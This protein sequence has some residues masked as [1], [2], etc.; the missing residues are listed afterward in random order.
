MFAF[1]FLLT[2]LVSF[3]NG[4][5]LIYVKSISFAVRLVRGGQSLSPS[6]ASDTSPFPFSFSTKIDVAKN[7]FIFSDTIIITG[8]NTAAIIRVSIGEYRIN[9]GDWVTD[10]GQVN[11]G[12]Q[13][14]HRSSTDDETSV[15]SRLTVGD[16]SAT[17]SSIT[18]T[19]VMGQPEIPGSSVEGFVTG[20]LTGLCH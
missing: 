3:V 9:Q 5:D 17:I 6:A 18:L 15:V 1:N 2:W 7:T 11:Q 14:R 19:E 10:N 8:I 12:D 4:D 13:L 16:V 20:H